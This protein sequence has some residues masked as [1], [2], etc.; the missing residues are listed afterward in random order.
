MDKRFEGL[1]EK[2]RQDKDWPKVY[3]FKFIIPND[4]QK[5]AQVEALFG[6]EAQVSI[7]QSRSNNYLSVTGK[8]MMIT[9]DEVIRRYEKAAEIEGLI[10]L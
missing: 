7:N 6:E 4:N 1:A 9:P 5:L 10:S 2:L 3:M 8:E